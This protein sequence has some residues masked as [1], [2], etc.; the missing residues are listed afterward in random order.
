MICGAVLIFYGFAFAA[1]PHRVGLAF[2][3]TAGFVVVAGLFNW[4]VWRKNTSRAGGPS[5][6]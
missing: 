4:L 6:P 5:N 2:A 3:V 1:K